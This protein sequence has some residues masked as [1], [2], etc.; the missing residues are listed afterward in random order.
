MN[1]LHRYQAVIETI[2]QG[3]LTKAAHQLGYTQ[4]GITH[5]LTTIEQDFG[6]RLIDRTK[7]GARPTPEGEFLLPFLQAV[8]HAE[9]NLREQ[10]DKIQGLETG[11][12][13]I[14]AFS[15]VSATFL[16]RLV[17]SFQEDH[18]NITFEIHHGNY[19]RIEALIKDR[20]VDIGF[21]RGPLKPPFE[22]ELFYS[23]QVL[24]LL[25]ADHANATRAVFPLAGFEDEPFV[26]LE[27]DDD[28]DYERFLE[29]NG[30]EVNT[31]FSAPEDAAVMALI[32]QG[33]GIGLGYELSLV[34]SSFGIVGVPLDTPFKRDIYWAV[35]RGTEPTSACQ[36][37]IDFLQCIDPKKLL[38]A[39]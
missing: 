31:I 38:P 26:M 39:D 19:S 7:K 35:K 10:I 34:K 3:S 29:R 4:S 1:N 27:A 12:I 8:L 14:G 30:I 18:P 33:L 25:P 36:S 22:G 28:N 23:D 15:S 20:V 16:P 17:K 37:F 9:E 2:Q 24:A 6:L 13:R 11:V 5:L 32:E 21:L